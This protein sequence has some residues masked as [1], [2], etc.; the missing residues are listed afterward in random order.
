VTISTLSSQLI[1]RQSGLGCSTSQVGRNARPAIQK[2]HFALRESA[3]SVGGRVIQ[4]TKNR[5][6]QITGPNHPKLYWGLTAQYPERWLMSRY[7][8][9][10]K[11]ANGKIPCNDL[12]WFPITRDAFRNGY[13]EPLSRAKAVA[14]KKAKPR[15]KKGAKPNQHLPLERPEWASLYDRLGCRRSLCCCLVRRRPARGEARRLLPM[16]RPCGSD[17]RSGVNS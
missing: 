4:R 7:Q 17:D 1:S 9:A 14:T 11:R 5:Y 13:S 2:N 8:S 10:P 3:G 6:A 15:R 12:R 16:R